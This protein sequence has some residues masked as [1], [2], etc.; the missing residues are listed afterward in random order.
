[1]NIS[2]ENLIVE[3]IL[4]GNIINGKFTIIEKFLSEQHYNKVY[5]KYNNNNN[6][7]NSLKFTYS[8]DNV[9]W[10][11]LP[12]VWFGV[13]IYNNKNATIVF[14]NLNH[15]YVI[16]FINMIEIIEKIIIEKVKNDLKKIVKLKSICKFKDNKIY[17]NNIKI[18][19]NYNDRNII[20]SKIY[21]KEKNNNNLITNYENITNKYFHIIAIFHLVGIYIKQHDSYIEIFPDLY[22]DESILYKTKQSEKTFPSN[23]SLINQKLNIDDDDYDG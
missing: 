3:N 2:S 13:D 22:L 12:K 19:L 16:N 21:L 10:K 18:K 14:E 1:M 5:I 9:N 8:V 15:D 17:I 7:N 20:N 23:S 6:S 11:H 4:Y